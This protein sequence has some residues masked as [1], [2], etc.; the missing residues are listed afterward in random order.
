VA[1]STVARMAH[2]AGGACA[3]GRTAARRDP[4]PTRGGGSPGSMCG[5]RGASRG[6]SRSTSARAWPAACRRS[7]AAGPPR[8]G[9]GCA[10]PRA[11]LVAERLPDAEDAPV[12]RQV[13][14]DERGR[15][16]ARRD[17]REPVAAAGGV[18]RPGREREHGREQV[19][20][21][22]EERRPRARAAQRERDDGREHERQ[23]EQVG[24][25]EDRRAGRKAGERE[26]PGRRRAP[27]P[28]ER[29]HHDRDRQRTERLGDHVAGDDRQRRVERDGRRRAD[30]PPRAGQHPDGIV[31]SPRVVVAVAERHAERRVGALVGRQERAVVDRV[32]DPPARRRRRGRVPG[33]APSAGSNGGGPRRQ[34]ADSAVTIAACTG[35]A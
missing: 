18:D 3:T 14:P 27:G 22:A 15:P 7:R 19:G 23:D 4:P 30:R 8:S 25:H 20:G 16:R 29:E 26:A 32:T 13:R 21:G 2:S 9:A 1:V 35:P 31:H 17:G 33:R 10:S 5:A 28:R 24:A 11:G 6:R 12:P 34:C